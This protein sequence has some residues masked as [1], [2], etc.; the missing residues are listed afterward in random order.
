MKSRQ[1][2]WLVVFTVALAVMSGLALYY[3][4]RYR[5]LHIAQNQIR[6]WQTQPI[7]ANANDPIKKQIIPDP[8]GSY[9]SYEIVG[10]LRVEDEA[11]KDE[12]IPGKVVIQN[13]PLKRE[14]P[15][16]VGALNGMTNFATIET[17]DDVIYATYSATPNS[18]VKAALAENSKVRFTVEFGRVTRYDPDG[19]ISRMLTA[20]DALILEY[21]KNEF[22]M[23]IPEDLL[24]VPSQLAVLKQ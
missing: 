24:L 7:A 23:P 22:A 6:E 4:F 20:M 11:R 13:D 9:V 1:K 17:I 19:Y 21:Q 8:N 3:F 10:D 18:L 16:L 2:L 5:Q 12:L 15:V 14:I